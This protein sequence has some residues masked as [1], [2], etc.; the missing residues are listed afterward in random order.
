[1]KTKFWEVRQ[2]K[3]VEKFQM[4]FRCA[5][6]SCFQVVTLLSEWVTDTFSDLQSLQS[7]QSIQSP[8]SPQSR[9]SPQSRSL[10]LNCG[11]NIS[12]NQK[13]RYLKICQ[14]RSSTSSPYFLKAR[15]LV[16]QTPQTTC[17]FPQKDFWERKN[18]QYYTVYRAIDGHFI[19]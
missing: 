10:Q 15:V 16:V 8:H 19:H 4:F 17:N 6:I 9:K 14:C 3:R 7:L 5:S 12:Q 1:M 2:A 18:Y 11:M 13:M